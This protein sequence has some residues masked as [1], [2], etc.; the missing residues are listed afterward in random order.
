MVNTRQMLSCAKM[1]KITDSK[2]T[3]P[4]LA[5]NCL[6]KTVVCVKNPGPIA[7]VAIKKAAPRMT[8]DREDFF[9]TI[10][11]PKIKKNL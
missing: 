7:E 5:S 10:S 8:D 6:V 4:K 11:S 3:K 9:I 2:I 1:S